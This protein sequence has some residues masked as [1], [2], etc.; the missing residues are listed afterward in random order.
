[1]GENLFSTKKKNPKSFMR[2]WISWSK[3]DGIHIV[4]WKIYGAI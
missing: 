3:Y 2:N 1:M 4:C